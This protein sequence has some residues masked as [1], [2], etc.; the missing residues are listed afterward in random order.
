M[1]EPNFFLTIS[2]LFHNIFS[3]LCHFTLTIYQSEVVKNIA[4]YFPIWRNTAIFRDLRTVISP[5]FK[6]ISENLTCR[7]HPQVK[8]I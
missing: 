4:V 6:G 3:Y 2:D 7:L 1:Y 8:T 5:L